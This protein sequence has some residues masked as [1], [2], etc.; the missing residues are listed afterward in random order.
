LEPRES[1]KPRRGRERQ[2]IFYDILCSILSQESRGT[3]KI[4]RVQN[5]VNLPS[6]RLRNHLREMGDLGLVKYDSRLASTRKGR[7]FVSEYKKV[8]GVLKRFGLVD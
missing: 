4:T 5:E 8:L 3:A 6:D 2:R 1:N 7:N